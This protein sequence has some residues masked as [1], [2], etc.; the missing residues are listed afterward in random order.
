[1]LLPLSV[2]FVSEDGPSFWQLNPY[3][4]QTHSRTVSWSFNSG[5]VV[6]PTPKYWKEWNTPRASWQG[7]TAQSTVKQSLSAYSGR[8]HRFKSH[9]EA[10]R[11]SGRKN[12]RLPGSWNLTFWNGFCLRS[13]LLLS[14]YRNAIPLRST[15]QGHWLA[16]HCQSI[17]STWV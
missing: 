1:M 13:K 8:L 14:A 3:A 11:T 4:I 17:P 2:H 7:P 16:G 15:S 5:F 9:Q 10:V 6:L 12:H